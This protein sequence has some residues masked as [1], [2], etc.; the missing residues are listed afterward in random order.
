MATILEGVP[1]ELKRIEVRNMAGS[2][3]PVRCGKIAIAVLRGGGADA[4]VLL[5]RRA[6]GILAGLWCQITGRVEA[7]ETGWEAALREVRE[8]TGIEP[9]RL[10][11]A[12]FCDFFYDPVANSV[13]ALPM[14]LALVPSGAEV[15]LNPENYEFRWVDPHAASEM[16]PF[17]GH[18]LAL[19]EIH[20][21]FI[22]N[23]P[24]PWRM[25]W[26]ADRKTDLPDPNAD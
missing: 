23:T 3:I 4:K 7:G 14:F 24:M 6:K 8:E 5:M 10:Y 17:V 20:R 21:D 11:S 9:A 2:D 19:R 26:A 15:R 22:E 18:R 25:L 16:V 1:Q 13:E 12:D